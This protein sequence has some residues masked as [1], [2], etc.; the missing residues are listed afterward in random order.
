MRNP[1]KLLLLEFGIQ[2]FGIK[3]LTLG[4][5]NLANDCNLES[6]IQDCIALYVR[7][8][9][10]KRKEW[11]KQTQSKW[12]TINVRE[13]KINVVPCFIPG[14][15]SRQDEANHVLRLAIRGTNFAY[16]N[17]SGFQASVVYAMWSIKAI[18]A[19]ADV[20]LA[21]HTIFPKQRRLSPLRSLHWI[22][23]TSDVYGLSSGFFFFF[24][25]CCFFFFSFCSF[26]YYHYRY[27]TLVCLFVCLLFR[28]YIMGSFRP[29]YIKQKQRT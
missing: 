7:W 9:K 3:N 19:H 15:A 14:A 26:C 29:C 24:V 16:L 22:L 11:S 28:G 21:R 13:S 6:R 10:F 8:G 27:L 18:A 17:R 20:L 23:S 12:W 1:G 4:I 2:S 5:Q 25:F